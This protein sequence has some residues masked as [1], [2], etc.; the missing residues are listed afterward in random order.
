M[1]NISL[2]ILYHLVLLAGAHLYWD[3]NKN[4]VYYLALIDNQSHIVQLLV[5][6]FFFSDIQIIFKFLTKIT[7]TECNYMI[8]SVL[9]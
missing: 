1:W 9:I 6:L 8:V 3:N 2:T 5:W 4:G 7:K